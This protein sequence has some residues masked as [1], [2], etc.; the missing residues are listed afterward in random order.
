MNIRLQI[1]PLGTRIEVGR[2]KLLSDVVLKAGRL[3]LD[4][5]V[6]QVDVAG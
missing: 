5:V 3:L 6:E 2:V 1:S 4:D